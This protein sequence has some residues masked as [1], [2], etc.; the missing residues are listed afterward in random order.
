MA[1][2]RPL[3][4]ASSVLILVLGASAAYAAMRDAPVSSASSARAPSGSGLVTVY[5]AKWCGPCHVLQDALK[6]KN[7]PFEY[8]DVDENPG[9]WSIVSK[10]ANSSSI[11][12]T[13]VIRGPH[14]K[15]IIGSNV[16]AVEAAYNEQ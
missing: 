15:W 9:V 7:I 12:V 4:I 10:S 11:P 3:A 1:S 16:N 2:R 6:A 5:G 13:S 14:I 8:V